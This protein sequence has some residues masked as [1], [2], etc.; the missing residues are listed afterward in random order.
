[1]KLLIGWIFSAPV[2]MCGAMV[3]VYFL[4]KLVIR[5]LV[6][7]LRGNQQIEQEAS[8]WL[9]PRYG[10]SDTTYTPKPPPP[11][12]VFV[13]EPFFPGKETTN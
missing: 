12:K 5:C 2:L 7:T 11:R 8:D 4:L 10:E 6:N 3:F 9:Y 13:Y 1:M